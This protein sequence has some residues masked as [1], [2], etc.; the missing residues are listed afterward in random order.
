MRYCKW[1]R[2]HHICALQGHVGYAESCVHAGNCSEFI[3]CQGDQ[4][5]L[6]YERPFDVQ[7]FLEY[8]KKLED[9]V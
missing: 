8:I 7:E 5:E 1:F 6:N 4:S 3:P 9:K 2:E